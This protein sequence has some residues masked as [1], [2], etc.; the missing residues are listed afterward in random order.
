MEVVSQ[1]ISLLGAFHEHYWEQMGLRN[2]PEPYCSFLSNMSPDRTRTY[3][4][5]SMHDFH[6]IANNHTVSALHH[7]EESPLLSGSNFLKV[8]CRTKWCWTLQ[9]NYYVADFCKVA[10]FHSKSLWVVLGP[11]W[12]KTWCWETLTVMPSEPRHQMIFGW[13]VGHDCAVLCA[14]AQQQRWCLSTPEWQR[15]LYS[16]RVLIFGK[17]T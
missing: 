2:D 11:W 15:K 6:R 5:S 10:L 3:F 7:S 17:K 4:R 16:S 9:T 8:V 12:Q 13:P 1:V 14:E